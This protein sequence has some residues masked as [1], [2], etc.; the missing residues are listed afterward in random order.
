MNPHEIFF[1]KDKFA[2]ELGIKLIQSDLGFAVLQLIIRDTHK[3]SHG[4]VH[5]GVI[6][7]LADCAFAV[8]SNSYKVPSVAINTS[9]SYLKPAISGK[10]TA[11]AKEFSNTPSTGVYTVEVTDE[12]NNLIAKFEGVAFHTGAIRSIENS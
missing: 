7:S 8:A 11:I 10:L 3:N 1:S 9:M 12:E 5:G 2:A 6:F 4:T